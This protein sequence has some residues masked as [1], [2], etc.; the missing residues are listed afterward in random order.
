MIYAA[1]AMWVIL[2]LLTGMGLYRLWARQLGGAL[3]DWLL[4][5]ATLAGELA[6]SAGR[7]MTGRP[8]YGGL[9]SPR[10]AS[11]DPCR[12]AISGRGGFLVSMLASLLVLTASTTAIVLLA[13]YLDPGVISTM[14]FSDLYIGLDRQL[15]T[16]WSDLW[17]MA[18]KQIDLLK[19][20]TATWTRLDWTD[21][22]VP[23]FVYLTGALAIRLGPV[24]HDQRAS[25]AVAAGIVGLAAIVGSVAEPVRD[26]LTGGD[27]WYLL[28]YVW[29]VLLFL[30]MVTLLMMG[31]VWLVRL[32]A[33]RRF[34]GGKGDLAGA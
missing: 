9:I 10:D 14:A 32:L 21:W 22:H 13:K 29:S 20:I 23:L 11:A 24:R 17:G 6:Y 3:V 1:L 12:N 16:G 8:A 28:T 2:I 18:E 30:L 5:P 25:L 4:L 7:M 31:I 34:A 27:L 26:M 15:P 19:G 33:P